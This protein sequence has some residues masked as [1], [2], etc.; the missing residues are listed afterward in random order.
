MDGYKITRILSPALYGDVV[1]GCEITSGDE[2]AIKRVNLKH[3]TRRQRIGSHDVLAEDAFSEVTIN[4]GLPYH[5]HV[6]QFRHSFRDGDVLHA[7]FDFCPGGDL[8][9]RIMDL[10][11]PLPENILRRYFYQITSGVQFLNKNGYCHGDLS[12]ENVFL[13]KNDDCCLGDLGLAW[14]L[15][16]LRSIPVGK[17]FY[18]PPEALTKECRYAPKEADLWSLG[19]VLF[20]MMF[21]CPPFQLA[22]CEEPRYQ[23]FQQRGLVG[24]L[25][26][27]KLYNLYSE[28]ALHL[29]SQLL[30]EDPSDRMPI[31]AILDH[32]WL[33]SCNDEELCNL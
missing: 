29:L 25:K 30:M 16:G 7:V 20:I 13:T 11:S 19:I 9:N 27:W 2:V 4:K 6:V 1:L 10:Q 26:G 31:E 15:H 17:P 22:S 28:S 12:L 5:D 18:M 21:R 33:R 32:P 14:P 24:L 23:Y 8:F 3:A